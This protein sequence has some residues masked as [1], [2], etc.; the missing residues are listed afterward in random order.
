MGIG[1][2]KLGK[3]C[4]SFLGI[5]ISCGTHGEGDQNLVRVQSR[6]PVSQITGLQVLDRQDNISCQQVDL[7]R[8]TPV[9]S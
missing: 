1:I 8:G 4:E 5:L 9:S 3:T 7:V 2:A 6:I